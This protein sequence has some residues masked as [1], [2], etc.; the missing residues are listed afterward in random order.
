MSSALPYMDDFLAGHNLASL[1][2]LAVVVGEAFARRSSG[3]LAPAP[4][5]TAR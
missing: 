1:E 3:D 4:P 5:A 2:S